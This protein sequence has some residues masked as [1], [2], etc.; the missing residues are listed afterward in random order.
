[1]ADTDVFASVLLF[2]SVPQWCTYLLGAMFLLSIVNLQNVLE[3]S[4]TICLR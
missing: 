2:I 3:E 1:M 4:K